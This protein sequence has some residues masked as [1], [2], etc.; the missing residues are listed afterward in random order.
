MY[1]RIFKFLGSI[2][3]AVPLLSIIGVILIGATFYESE[4]GSTTVQHQIYQSPWFGA[5]MFLLAVNLGVS[6]LNRYPWKGARKVGFALT[7]LG[8]IVIIAGSAAVIHLGLEGM[9]LLHTDGVTN[10]QI[11]IEGELVEVVNQKGELQRHEVFVKSDGSVS[12]HA[13]AGLSLLGYSENTIKTVRFTEGANVANPALRLSLHSDRMGQN[14][15]RWLAIAPV[16]YSKVP[17]GPAQLEIVAATDNRQLQSLLTKPESQSRWGIL[18]INNQEMDVESNLGEKISAGDFQVKLVNFWSDFRLNG[19]GKI[20]NASTQ[21]NNPALQLEVAT[22]QGKERWFVFA[23]GNFPPIRSLIEG[24]SLSGIEISYQ[25]TPQEAEDYFRVIVNS[26]NQ[27]YYAAK[28]SQGFQS[29]TLAMGQV[30]NPGWAD[31]EI[32]LEEFIADGQLQRDIVPVS[33]SSFAGVPALLVATES[34]EQTW[35]SWGEPTAIRE[36]EGEIFAAFSPKLLQLPFGIKLEDFIVERNEGSESVAMWTSAISLEQPETGMVA[37]RKVWMNHPTWYQGWKIAQASWNPGDLSQSTLQ[38][39]REP[40]WVTALTWGGSAL[41][42]LGIG[43]MFYAPMILKK[44][45][46]RKQNRD[47]DK[48]LGNLEVGENLTIEPIT[49]TTYPLMQ[50]TNNQQPITK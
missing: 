10:N 20:A 41:V 29:G 31:F 13:V 49:S 6:A 38:V 33:K 39:K 9:I 32:T 19:D 45:A 23:K 35:L 43:I 17:I 4:V 22:S 8:L 5:L 14:L 37:T 28:S 3:L 1:D 30:V 46:P 18:Q 44:L 2:K 16:S 34:G 24:E 11:R 15:E 7:H 27:L 25:V 42:V 21:L 48:D 40:A 47:K 50:T 12:P 26:D 36:A